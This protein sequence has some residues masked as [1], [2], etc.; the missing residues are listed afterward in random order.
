MDETAE[1]I[2]VIRDIL[3]REIETINVYQR[4]AANTKSPD[5]AGF[6]NHIIEEEKEHVAEALELIKRY[7]LSQ[8]DLLASERDWRHT[9][10]S[11]QGSLSS[12]REDSLT[13]H[14]FTVGALKKR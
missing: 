1:E 11:K 7:D 13:R 6:L 2:M 5:V 4:M 8:A 3:I 14:I 12:V 10:E 9:S